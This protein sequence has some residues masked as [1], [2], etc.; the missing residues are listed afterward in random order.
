MAEQY[1][2]QISLRITDVGCDR[3]G[4]PVVRGLTMAVEPGEAVQLFGPNG[5]G[6]SSLLG[7]FAGLIRPSEGI[8]EWR[9]NTESRPD[10][11]DNTIFFL[12]HE[13]AV[14]PA[15][16][17]SEN[18]AFW[19]RL[20]GGDAQLCGHALN[21]VGMST[22]AET[23]VGAMSAGQ[24]RRIDLA[25]ADLSPREVWLLDEPTAALDADGNA[26]ACEMIRAH[27]G[28]GGVAII[29]THEI[30]DVPAR[31]LELMR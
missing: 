9:S 1:S 26:I 27:L 11:F 28:R 29:A 13:A 22:M 20:D 4:T 18:L 12:G 24:R 23:R 8:I 14:K 30:L 15:L 19:A 21:R 5:S 17:A 2:R 16:T 6:K 10:P 25:R 31:R 3:A 7:M